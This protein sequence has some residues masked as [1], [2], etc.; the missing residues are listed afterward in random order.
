MKLIIN[1]DD[2]GISRGT[3]YGIVDCI[4]EGILTTATTMMNAP[5]TNHA[6]ELIKQHDLKVGIHLVGTMFKPLTN[7]PSMMDTDGKFHKQRVYAQEEVCLDE[8][9]AEWTAQMELFIK[10]TGKLPTHIDSHHGV[11]ILPKYKA[12]SERLIAKYQIPSRNID[13]PYGEHVP[14]LREF[15]GD[16]VSIETIK[17]VCQLPGEYYELMTHPGYTDE[18]IMEVT[19]Y[20]S[21]R[22]EE[23]KVLM[24]LELKEYLRSA[25]VELITFADIKK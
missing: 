16:G 1:A 5:A 20:N 23:A 12:I 10:L 18:V 21:K 15:Y 14:L 11:H 6:I 7:C 3:N 22:K 4:T 13:T 24:D 8:L 19:S 25:G 17:A 9:E 2:F